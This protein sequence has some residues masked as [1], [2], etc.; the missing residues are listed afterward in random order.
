[1]LRKI[2]F[3]TFMLFQGVFSFLH[4]HAQEE[5]DNQ[6]QDEMLASMLMFG[7]RGIEIFNGTV[8]SDPSLNRLPF[9]FI[10]FDRDVTSNTD[11][12]IQS[13]GQLKK[14][15][16]QLQS[17]SGK[18]VFIAVDQ[19]GGQVRRLKPQKGFRELESA[20]RMG[21]ENVHATIE[22]SSRLGEELNQL[23]INV[24]LAPVADVDSNPFNP[25]IGKLGRAFNS[26]P[27]LAAAHA[28]AFGQG[29]AKNRVIPVLKHF[30]GQ[31]CAENDN[32]VDP[33]DIT[34]CW[35]ADVD[36]L[37]FAEIFRAGWPGMVMMGHLSLKSLDDKLPATLSANIVTGLLRHGMNWQGV[38]I[39]DDMQMK[40]VQGDRT[41]KDN[42]R[43]AIEAGNDI[44]LFGNNLEWDENLPRK[45]WDSL[46]ELKRE[47]S[48]TEERI[49]QSWERI[50]A[51]KKA[52]GI[53][54]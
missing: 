8:F 43:L 7:F 18:G 41:L 2:I 34:Q 33:V 44:L 36:L 1:M 19:E 25:L 4:A 14:L 6:T 42:L 31:G 30:P 29:L 38:I 35:N 48:L 54:A 37:P 21:Q 23:G 52:Y 22:K 51:L 12:N 46:Q 49:R 26:D 11:R 32:H 10:I 15:T 20:Q 47:G 24:D 40:G 16:G 28:L 17:L 9:N 13:P 27:A 50:N 53:D 3:L 45:V 5:A 39:T